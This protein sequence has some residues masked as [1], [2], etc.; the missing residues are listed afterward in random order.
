M[1]DS[2]IWAFVLGPYQ[3][4]LVPQCFVRPTEAKKAAD[5]AKMRFAHIDGDHLTLLNV[6]HAF[7]QSKCAP[8][9][10][11]LLVVLH[12]ASFCSSFPRRVERLGL[13]FE[14]FYLTMW[15]SYLSATCLCRGNKTEN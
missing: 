9:V 1:R 8:V 5:E 6:Y 14:P 7:K 13:V 11:N 3:P 4:C 10:E 15:K 2:S 12:A